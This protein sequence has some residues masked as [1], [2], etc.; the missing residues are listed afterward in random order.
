MNLEQCLKRCTW[1]RLWGIAYGRG[2]TVPQQP[3]KDDLLALVEIDMRRPGAL[4]ENLAKLPADALTALQ[5]LALHDGWLPART[6]QRRFGPLRALKGQVGDRTAPTPPWRHPLSNTE[7]LWYH[8]LIYP[9]ARP[10][11]HP[12]LDPN[13]F[14]LPDELA[15]LLPPPPS[16]VQP[17]STPI[18]PPDPPDLLYNLTS[19]LAYLA[20]YEGRVR[21]GRWLTPGQFRPLIDRFRPSGCALLAADRRCR[22]ERATR[23]LRALHFVAEAA[24]FLPLPPT[25]GPRRT[26]SRGRPRKIVRA[27]TGAPPSP[28]RTV[29]ID[30]PARPHPRAIDSPPEVLDLVPT[31]HWHDWLDRPAPEQLALLRRTLLAHTPRQVQ[32]WRDYALPG[33]K[34]EDPLAPMYRL[35]G[36]LADCPTD[37]T[38]LDLSAFLAHLSWRYL[39]LDPG[40]HHQPDDAHR[41][42]LAG[43]L[44]WLGL[45][46]L[47]RWESPTRFRL[48]PAGA[49]LVGHQNTSKGLLWSPAALRIISFEQQALSLSVDPACPPALLYQLQTLPQIEW[50][51]PAVIHLTPGTLAHT[52]GR[53]VAALVTVLNAGLEEPLSKEAVQAIQRW[54]GTGADLAIRQVTLLESGAPNFLAHLAGQR[55]IRRHFRRSFGR[56]AVQLD[57]NSLESLLRK[58]RRRGI[59]PEMEGKLD[60][61]D[62]PRPGHLWGPEDAGHL[63]LAARLYN[64]LPAC[65][66]PTHTIPQPTLDRLAGGLSPRILETVG[67]MVKAALGRLYDLVDGRYAPP[68]AVRPPADEEER[69][70]ETVHHALEAGQI[71][72]IAYYTAGRGVLTRRTVDPL[73]MEERH[74][75][76]YLVGYCHLRRAERVFRVDRIIEAEIAAE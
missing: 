53:E 37:G 16:P 12:S 63:L 10:Q 48:T 71:L 23:H 43:F 15:P 36:A 3:S 66:R 5:L 72:E 73:R 19:F 18:D 31:L 74:G 4:A 75:V 61:A 2:L 38:W 45:V 76:L 46:Q 7:Q 59:V 21:Q 55:G 60:P 8:G 27:R 28:R 54:A 69:I 41:R 13:G 6:F 49:V 9:Q 39:E 35:K 24:G 57:T 11:G 67:Q 25:P 62:R 29:R 44:A 58:L 20:R 64:R 14:C 42:V 22:G 65:I 1:R 56:H 32:R 34:E 52:S 26:W 30:D 51:G 47:D 70:L 17:A 40:Q 50:P 33:S 68:P